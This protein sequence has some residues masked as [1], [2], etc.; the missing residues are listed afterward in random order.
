[1]PRMF[2]LICR[3]DV[4]TSGDCLKKLQAAVPVVA[5]NVA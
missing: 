5:D 1:M 2:D 3:G 4:Y